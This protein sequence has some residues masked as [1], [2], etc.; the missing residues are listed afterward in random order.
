MYYA[1]LFAVTTVVAAVVGWGTGRPV[2]GAIVAA[3]YAAFAAAILYL[4]RGDTPDRL[5]E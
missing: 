4:S 5:L 2:A 1:G 3:V